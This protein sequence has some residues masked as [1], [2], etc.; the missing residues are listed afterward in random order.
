MNSCESCQELISRLV[1]GEISHDEHEALMAHMKTCSRCNAMYAVFH[2]LSDILSEESEELPEGLHENIMAG[3]RRSDMIRKNRRM[4]KLGL[5]TALAAAACL[6]LVLFAASGFGPD[7]RRDNIAVRSES[8]AAGLPAPA[9]AT[10]E[11]AA[12]PA[13]APVYAAPAETP[14]Y[15]EAPVYTPAPTVNTDRTK[16]DA[17]LAEG[18]NDEAQYSTPQPVPEIIYQPVT[19]GETYYPPAPVYNT[20][21]LVYYAPAPVYDEPAPA[22]N[23]APAVTEN[24]ASQRSASAAPASPE[25][26]FSASAAVEE[27][28]E[29][30]VLNMF[31]GS[32]SDMGI[33][34][35]SPEE[36]EDVESEEPP[37]WETTYDETLDEGI[38]SAGPEWTEP[39]EP[40]SPEESEKPAAGSAEEQRLT[41]RG[42][43]ARGR[44]L[45][46]LGGSEEILPEETEL[47]RLIRLTLVSEDAYGGEEKLDVYV[48]G[49]FVF[50]RL[51][52]PEGGSTDYRAS[53]SLAELDGLLKTLSAAPTPTPAPTPDPY[54]DVE[55]EL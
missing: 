55:L 47:T 44:L 18:G 27:P 43:E 24:T 48:Y 36:S 53:C 9:A 40:A 12:S 34:A 11:P 14:A 29:E 2:D 51:Y 21:A 6:V 7:L 15:T 50:Y 30:I 38:E 45:A 3:V 10:A 33:F 17:Y 25:E 31:P 41:I 32:V 35:A 1:D 49:D 23:E 20:P 8:E 22:Q 37:V 5:R 52:A 46:L 42:K 28:E 16:P 39:E 26:A 54:A 4:C 19:Q 13:A